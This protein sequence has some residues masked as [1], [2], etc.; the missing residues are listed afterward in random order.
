MFSKVIREKEKGERNRES[1][2]ESESE[3]QTDHFIHMKHF[4]IQNI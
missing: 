1:E 2:R 4:D 3:R